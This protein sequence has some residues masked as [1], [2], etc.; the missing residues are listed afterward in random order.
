MTATAPH[1]AHSPGAQ[2]L[3]S[4]PERLSQAAKALDAGPVA[5]WR[6]QLT[7][8]E[9]ASAPRSWAWYELVVTETGNVHT[10]ELK[11]WLDNGDEFVA[12]VVPERDAAIDVARFGA[13]FD[14]TLVSATSEAAK[15]WL[16]ANQSLVVEFW[17]N[18]T[19]GLV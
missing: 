15:A 12:R 11:V 18:E 4:L 3:P 17:S 8:E 14:V 16:A 6:E 19:K 5:E 2:A 13:S 7:E 1:P 10:D 9:L